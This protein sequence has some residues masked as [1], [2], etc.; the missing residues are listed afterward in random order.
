MLHWAVKRQ[1]NLEQIGRLAAATASIEML[2]A[3]NIMYQTA[4]HLAVILNRPD[5]AFV[6]VSL[7]ASL[8]R[9]EQLH[10][11]TVLHLACRLGH[12]VCLNTIFDAWTKRNDDSPD[13]VHIKAILHSSNY[14]GIP[15]Q[16][17]RVSLLY[18]KEANTAINCIVINRR[19]RHFYLQYSTK[20]SPAEFNIIGYEGPKSS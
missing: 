10:G 3:V 2:D 1:A 18:V 14:E 8:R 16:L 4:L 13:K 17:C 11:D 19:I 12:G 9:Q 6:L 20:S 15:G 5:V 7:G